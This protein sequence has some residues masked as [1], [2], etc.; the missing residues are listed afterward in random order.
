MYYNFVGADIPVIVSG[1]KL[2][3]LDPQKKIWRGESGQ[4]Y[5]IHRIRKVDSLAPFQGVAGFSAQARIYPGTLFRFPLRNSAS[6][7]S[8][9]LYTI[10]I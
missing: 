8:E 10:Q 7:L 1:G 5:P 4:S 2:A 3:F 9:N 6:V